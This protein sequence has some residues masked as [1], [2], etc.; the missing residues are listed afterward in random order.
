[1]NW[2]ELSEYVQLASGKPFIVGEVHA[3]GGGD[4]NEAYRIQGAN[5]TFFVKL[6]RRDLEL[7]FAAEAAGLQEIAETESVRTPEVIAHGKTSGHAFIVLENLHLKPLNSTSERVLG[8]QLAL[9]HQLRQPYFGWHSDNT[10]G[11]TAQINGQTDDWL[12][13]WRI[14]RIEFQLK[15]A[16][17]K[18]YRG[19]LQSLGA[20][21]CDLI[22]AFFIG[23][24]PFP[25]LLHGDLWGG[26]AAM[27]RE[28][29]PVIF[30]PA[31]YYGDR[32]ADLAMTE[33]FGGYSRDF[34]A[35]YNEALPLDSGYVVRKHFY[36]LYHILNHLNLFGSGYLRQAENIMARLMAEVS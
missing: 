27:T 33:L 10:I 14:Q 34:Y 25:S 6:N 21:L 26:N 28:A 1:M 8:R 16:A 23:Y 36:N 35:A 9:M 31:C 2:N 29:E 7:M 20:Q 4:I 19:R 11:S 15:L 13:F 12:Q 32:E 30:D 24:T 18:G 22:P 3:V 5:A 17:D